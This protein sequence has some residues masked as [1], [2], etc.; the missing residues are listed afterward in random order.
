[1]R[2]LQI[3]CVLSRQPI[4]NNLGMSD[5]GRTPARRPLHRTRQRFRG[6]F[7]AVRQHFG[8]AD[9]SRR[10]CDRHRT[11]NL[12]SDH[13]RHS[14]ASQPLDQL[15]VIERIALRRYVKVNR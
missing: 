14:H 9:S 5:S 8:I 2:S 3:L 7:E 6:G 13:H 10:A 1:M 15:F 11:A 4:D 12:L